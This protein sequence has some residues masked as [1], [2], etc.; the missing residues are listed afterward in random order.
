LIAAGVQLRSAASTLVVVFA[1]VEI[2]ILHLF[3]ARL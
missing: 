3:P 2:L 1:V